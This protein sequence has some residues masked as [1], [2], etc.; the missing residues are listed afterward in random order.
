MSGP[1]PPGQPGGLPSPESAFSGPAG[2]SARRSRSSARNLLIPAWVL[3][4]VG[5]V[6][7][8]PGLLLHSSFVF[9]AAL[10]AVI[11]AI[12]LFLVRPLLMSPRPAVRL[13]AV[14]IILAVVLV[15]VLPV[16]LLPGPLARMAADEPTGSA[17][18]VLRP[19]ASWTTGSGGGTMVHG[20]SGDRF[21]T[22]ELSG[23]TRRS[24][25]VS[26]RDRIWTTP[27]GQFAYV[28]DGVSTQAFAADGTPLGTV[29]GIPL[30]VGDEGVAVEQDRPRVEVVGFD[31]ALEERIWSPADDLVVGHGSTAP[32]T[33]GSFGAPIELSGAGETLP[34][35]LIGDDLASDGATA[36][37]PD[38]GRRQSLEGVGG[39][40][41]PAGVSG[42]NSSIVTDGGGAAALITVTD[43]ATGVEHLDPLPPQAKAYTVGES[44]FASSDEELYILDD[45]SWIPVP[46]STTDFDPGA[47]QAPASFAT[48]GDSLVVAYGGAVRSH[49][50]TRPGAPVQWERDDLRC[51]H[52][53]HP[54]LAVDHGVA[55]IAC[56]Y[57]NPVPI[58]VDRS[59]RTFVLDAA[60]G[61]TQAVAA[62]SG[63]SSSTA[64][65][66]VPGG[67][68]VGEYPTGEDSGDIPPLSIHR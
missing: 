52:D 10:V 20:R 3:L 24:V 17:E 8:V 11:T 33:V 25:A 63:L 44:H 12:L 55:A 57:R 67:I 6:L 56:N 15:L 46:V 4:T 51:R 9:A 47:D 60:D 5:I 62:G 38:T 35:I 14:P 42:V 59:A 18:H 2:A 40:A 28:F 68:V 13:I 19:E 58:A 45:T 61:T 31:R 37:D 36:L 50:L 64:L 53:E 66:A 30:A 41:S 39:G 7:I 22:Y 27:D 48:D 1:Y 32:S 29:E 49:D 21:L 54:R 16:M 43:D 65:L 34:A 23:D 26:D